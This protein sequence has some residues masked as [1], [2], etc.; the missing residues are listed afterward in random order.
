MLSKDP[1]HGGGI[2]GTEEAM[3]EGEDRAKQVEAN[4]S[5]HVD[6]E[7]EEAS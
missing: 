6:M 1:E 7:R 4:M 5:G 3:G 2:K